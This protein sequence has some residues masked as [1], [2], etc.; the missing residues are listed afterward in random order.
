MRRHA[1]VFAQLFALLGAAALGGCFGFDLDQPQRVHD[2]RVLAARLDPPELELPLDPGAPPVDLTL[3]A[4]VVDPSRGLIEAQVRGCAVASAAG[5]EAPD[6]LPAPLAP[7]YAAAQHQ[8]PLPAAPA[9]S[10][11][12][13]S[14]TR[15]L[16]AAALHALFEAAGPT[17]LGSARPVYELD[18]QGEGGAELALKRLPI[19]L[20][21]LAFRAALAEAGLVLCDDLGLPEGCLPYQTRV[22]NQNPSLTGLGVRRAGEAEPTPHDPATPLTLA[23]GEAITLHISAA[24]GDDEA[25]QTLSVDLET[26][27]VLLEDR[28]EA[29]SFKWFATQA[30]LGGGTTLP[31]DLLVTKNTVRAPAEVPQG[32]LDLGLWVVLRDNRG[33]VD[34]LGLALRVE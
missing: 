20:P 15:S 7:F 21:D 22:P 24:E 29:L 28:V 27:T 17:A 26:R 3:T 5:C 2:L 11:A 19:S 33:G 14:D 25:Y 13:I 8:A 10:G 18:V 31:D 23:P 4:L 34:F 1:P 12:L 6:P 32:G 9:P 30:S 16:D